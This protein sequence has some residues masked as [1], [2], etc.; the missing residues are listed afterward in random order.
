MPGRLP[1]GGDLSPCCGRG[2]QRGAEPEDGRR[3]QQRTAPQ[4]LLFRVAAH[5]SQTPEIAGGQRD[6][7]GMTMFISTPCL[8]PDR[9]PPNVSPQHWAQFVADYEAFHGNG[10]AAKAATLGWSDVQLFG[11][12]RTMREHVARSHP[13]R[14]RGTTPKRPRPP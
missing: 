2:G 11:C 14:R 8:D 4:I 13:K 10:L 12:H 1:D 6:M 5:R 7:G 9:P 3:S